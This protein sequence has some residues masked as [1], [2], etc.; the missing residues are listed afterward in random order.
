[1][2]TWKDC[3]IS[4][5][6][7]TQAPR[8]SGPLAFCLLWMRCLGLK[9]LWFLNQFLPAKGR[10]QEYK[11]IQARFFFALRYSKKTKQSWF[12]SQSIAEAR[13]LCSSSA[14]GFQHQESR[15][16]GLI[17]VTHISVTTRFDF[18][19]FSIYCRRCV[20]RFS[21]PLMRERPGVVNELRG[22]V[23]SAL[24][25][26]TT[27]NKNTCIT[28]KIRISP[29]VHMTS[30]AVAIA[31]ISLFLQLLPRWLQRQFLRAMLLA[32]GWKLRVSPWN[33]RRRKS[34]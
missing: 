32:K 12:Q 30:I 15:V 16:R 10:F 19:H 31:I 11:I 5:P 3:S 34:R 13:A 18:Q 8:S 23:V 7:G 21:W 28:K 9:L 20:Q 25:P 33:L 1:M 24:S 17:P 6:W 4:R 29:K 2:V 22:V 27:S 26:K 14:H